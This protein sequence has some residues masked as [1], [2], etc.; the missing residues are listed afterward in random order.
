[1]LSLEL[2]TG[3]AGE[4]GLEWSYF[5]HFSQDGSQGDSEK[6]NAAMQDAREKPA[7]DKFLTFIVTHSCEEY[8]IGLV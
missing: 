2:S 4:T 3:P 5:K 6:Q 7:S 8:L 1:M